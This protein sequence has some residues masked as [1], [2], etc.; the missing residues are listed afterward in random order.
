M[1]FH[2]KIREWFANSITDLWGEVI[3]DDDHLPPDF[4]FIIHFSSITFAWCTFASFILHILY[5]VR[6][7]NYSAFPLAEKL[8]FCYQ[9]VKFFQ[10]CAALYFVYYTYELFDEDKLQI[11]GG[12]EFTDTILAAYVGLSAF[13]L[14]VGIFLARSYYKMMIRPS[15][16]KGIK[17]WMNMIETTLS[18]VAFYGLLVTKKT[19]SPQFLAIFLLGMRFTDVSQSLVSITKQLEGQK[20]AHPVISAIGK[21]LPLQYIVREALVLGAFFYC[22]EN[23]TIPIVHKSWVVQELLATLAFY[24]FI[25][26]PFQIYQAVMFYLEP[27]EEKND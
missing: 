13:Q 11:F 17:A 25:L 1:E 27:N 3:K 23:M 9:S 18:V 5:S 6:F 16:S 19:E 8:K 2:W 22:Y 7:E 26:T 4:Q 21:S 12:N 10:G 24:A 15:T 14:L 20:D